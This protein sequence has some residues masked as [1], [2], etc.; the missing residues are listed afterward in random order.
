MPIDFTEF[1]TNSLNSP[2]AI[3]QLNQILRT[4]AN[5]VAGDTESVRIYSGYGTPEGNI[6]AGIGSMYMRL[7][8]GANTSVYRKESGTGNTGWVANT[9]VTLPL[10]VANGGTGADFS[11]SLQGTILYFSAA[12][13]LSVLGTGTSGYFLK[14]QGAN[15]NPI[16]DIVSQPIGHNLVSITSISSAS[17]TGSITLSNNKIYFVEFDLRNFSTGTNIQLT[18]NSDTVAHYK[19]I[20]VGA[21]TTGAIT[22]S[23]ASAASIQ[24]GRDVGSAATKGAQGSFY[25][26]QIGST[27][28]YRVWGQVVIDDNTATLFATLNFAGTWSNSAN[29]SSFSI[30]P[31]SGTFDGTVNLYELKTS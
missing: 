15:A 30:F 1:N 21:T 10:S 26:Q 4:I 14:T 11:G 24:I 20:N 25:I 16:W 22:S 9:N 5:N 13:V 23:S 17:S 19:Y 2:D 3:N 18:F 27:Q 6:T 7:D 12:G 29:I 8:G 31:T 28:N